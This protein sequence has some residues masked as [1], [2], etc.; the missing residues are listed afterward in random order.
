MDQYSDLLHLVS[1]NASLGK[2]KPVDPVL[3]QENQ[4]TMENCHPTM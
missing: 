3:F 2:L 4:L 1:T